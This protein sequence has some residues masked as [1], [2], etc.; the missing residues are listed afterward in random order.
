M[1]LKPKMFRTIVDK[2]KMLN[3]IQA[4]NLYK[5]IKFQLLDVDLIKFESE[6][7]FRMKLETKALLSAFHNIFVQKLQA[8]LNNM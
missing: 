2:A 8:V 6:L 3:L 5:I 1:V 4:I 7:Y